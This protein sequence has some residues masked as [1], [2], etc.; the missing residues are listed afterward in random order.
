MCIVIQTSP[1]PTATVST[2]GDSCLAISAPGAENHV[3]PSLPWPC[4]TRHL[5]LPQECY[6]TGMHHHAWLIQ[7]LPVL[8]LRGHQ[9]ILRSLVILGI[10]C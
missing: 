9:R 8:I 2:R 5:P 3:M 7:N 4:R 6:A 10:K 1:I